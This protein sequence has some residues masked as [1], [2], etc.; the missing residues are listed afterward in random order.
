MRTLILFAI[1]VILVLLLVPVLL[2]CILFRS[3]SPLFAIGRWALRVGQRILGLRLCVSGLKEI[4]QDRALVFM[5]NHLS[6]LDGPLMFL[7]IPRAVRVILKKEIFRIPIIGRAMRFVEFVPV[8]RKGIKGGK[9]SIDRATH[10]IQKKGF[11]FLIFPEGTRSRDGR[12]QPFKRGGFF[13][14]V[15]SHTDIVPISIVGTFELM[16][17]GQFF[18]RRGTIKVIFFPPVSVEGKGVQDLPDLMEEVR[19]AIVSGLITETDNP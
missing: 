5:P 12:L 19:T 3:V 9:R 11:S 8:D 7:I 15:N 18:V 6:F 13:L 10:L 2:L 16:P 4:D 17:K 14:A 1:Y